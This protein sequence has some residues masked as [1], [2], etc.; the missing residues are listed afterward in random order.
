MVPR[1]TLTD[2]R[3]GAAISKVLATPSYRQEAARFAERL[4]AQDAVGTACALIE[5]FLADAV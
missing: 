2:E 5:G 3:L 1:A 4:Q